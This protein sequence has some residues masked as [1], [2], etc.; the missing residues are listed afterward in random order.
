MLIG[1]V[2]TIEPERILEVL[3]AL[4]DQDVA[5]EFEVIVVDRIQDSLS[6]EIAQA[7]PTFNVMRCG[8]RLPL[9]A[10]RNM[11][12][13][14]ARGEIVVVTEDHCVPGTTWLRQIEQSFGEHPEAA[15][16]AGT[17]ENGTSTLAVDRA[18]YLC[19]YAEFTPPIEP[20]VTDHL[21]GVNIAY[22]REALMQVP[23]ELRRE[24]FWEASVHPWLLKRGAALIATN[25]IR[26]EHRKRIPFA[27][28]LAHRMA[29]SRQYA[30][31][32]FPA[33]AWL[34]RVTAALATPLLPLLLAARLLRSMVRSPQVARQASSAAPL[35]LIFYVV[36]A[37]GEFVGY[38]RGPG[39]ALA[40]VE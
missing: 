29:Y 24:R 5:G 18:T 14:A 4:Q 6:T 12:L 28:F 7:H 27:K 23:V 32:R 40:E 1:R 2:S 17:V 37:V 20:G 11:A 3:Q 15:A 38:L 31:L 8:E 16:I 10:M 26:I 22:R 13:E 34:R 25:G 9:P 33:Q 36:W 35:L 30:G 19:E 21:C 39:S